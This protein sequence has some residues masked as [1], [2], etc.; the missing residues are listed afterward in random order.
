MGGMCAYMHMPSSV[1][2]MWVWAGE[3][4]RRIC[5]KGSALWLAVILQQTLGM[6]SNVL[7]RPIMCM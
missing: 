7:R 3:L 4:E 2:A 5:R 6:S 1:A